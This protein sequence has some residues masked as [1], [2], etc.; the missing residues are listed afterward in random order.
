MKHKYF[1][2]FSAIIVILFIVYL[3]FYTFTSIFWGYKL[4]YP[5]PNGEYCL[6]QR[7]TEWGPG[8]RGKTYLVCGDQRWFVDD[9]GPGY[10]GWLSDT[11]FYVGH[12]YTS[13]DDIIY[14]ISD[15]AR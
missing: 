3:C 7:Y 8:Y 9:W 11:Q 4:E 2:L 6:E 15:F 10:A 12:D 5:S 13:G 14:S 1:W